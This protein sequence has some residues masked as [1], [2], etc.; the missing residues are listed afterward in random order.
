MPVFFSPLDIVVVCG[1]VRGGGG[2]VVIGGGGG[3]VIG[4]GSGG[5][6]GGGGCDVCV[7]MCV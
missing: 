7:Y 3:V 1:R 5:N 6:D 4:G 2:G